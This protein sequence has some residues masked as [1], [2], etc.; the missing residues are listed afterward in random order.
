MYYFTLRTARLARSKLLSQLS[1][2]F[3]RQNSVECLRLCPG[4]LNSK[5]AA[6][7]D[8]PVFLHFWNMD[9]LAEEPDEM[10]NGK[11]RVTL[12][13]RKDAKDASI[14]ARQAHQE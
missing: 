1:S 13:S 11:A 14:D 3:R 8:K 5:K 2:F 6:F 12:S 9:R 4:R 7:S 10:T